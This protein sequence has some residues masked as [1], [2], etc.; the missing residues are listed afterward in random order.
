[1]LAFRLR[2]PQ[3]GTDTL[4]MSR[5]AAWG[6][7]DERVTLPNGAL[8]AQTVATVSKKEILLALMQKGRATVFRGRACDAQALRDQ[9]GLRQNIVAWAEALHWGWPDGG[10]AEWNK[11]Y[12]DHGDLA[13]G[14]PLHEAVA[15]AFF[16]QRKYSIGCYT[17]TKLVI[18]QATLDYYRRIKGDMHTFATI[19][20]RLMADG[21]PLQDIEPGAMWYFEAES[22]KEDMATQGKLLKLATAVP[23]N[24]FIPGDWAY[25]LNT[26]SVTYEKTGYE[27]SNALYLGRGKFDDYYD[28][29][30]HSYTYKEK[31]D[32]VYQWRNKVFNRQRDA[33]K[34]RPLTASEFARLT[35]SPEQGGLQLTYRAVPYLFGYE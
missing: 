13:P 2:D 12:W 27:G 29:H 15:D 25:F 22:T 11:A 34:L 7:S 30:S 31:L 26:D 35:L 4:Q 9:V 20:N 23:S 14:V 5:H 18:I 28:D 6:L 33:D 3:G 21:E 17:A 24:N 16:N 32:E 10:A 8:P 1:M 19:H